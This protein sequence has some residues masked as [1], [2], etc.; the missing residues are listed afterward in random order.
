MKQYYLFLLYTL[1]IPNTSLSL[2]TECL[3]R[4]DG[5]TSAAL[6]AHIRDED[7][8]V[9]AKALFYI[10]VESIAGVDGRAFKIKRFTHNWTANSDL[11]NIFTVC[12]EAW[13]VLVVENY[14]EQWTQQYELAVQNGF[15]TTDM[16]PKAANDAVT[17]FRK[18]K[19][20]KA[21][22]TKIAKFNQ[23]QSETDKK[24]KTTLK[25]SGNVSGW[26]IE[27]AN[28]YVDVFMVIASRRVFDI[29]KE[30]PTFNQRFGKHL[31]TISKE[32]SPDDSSQWFGYDGE[33]YLAMGKKKKRKSSSS[34]G[35]ASSPARQFKGN[36]WG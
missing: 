31:Y 5:I 12:A 8:L 36:L 16:T 28:R 17:N 1:G 27:G 3:H 6:N 35:G 34:G 24:G 2:F 21:L 26:N 15:V 9:Y 30:T 10:G 22:E 4:K 13:I 20:Y 33:Q 23:A 11:N 7:S 18:I 14:E 25:G 32:L 29:Q 19:K